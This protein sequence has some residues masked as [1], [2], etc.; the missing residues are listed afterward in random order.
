MIC[1]D[2]GYNRNL[3]LLSRRGGGGRPTILEEESSPLPAPLRS[4]HRPWCLAGQ[5]AT[6]GGEREERVL[7]LLDFLLLIPPK[8]N[9][10]LSSSH[11]RPY[12]DVLGSFL[13][14]WRAD[15]NKKSCRCPPH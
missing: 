8:Q 10:T 12:D 13:M 3:P 2:R 4:R 14:V 9:S 7:V 11:E 5:E 15:K 1:D 6:S